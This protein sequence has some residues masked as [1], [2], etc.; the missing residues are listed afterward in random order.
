MLMQG[1][2]LLQGGRMKEQTT[3]VSTGISCFNNIFPCTET[4][5]YIKLL[6]LNSALLTL[7]S[8][9][10]LARVASTIQVESSSHNTAVEYKQHNG[11]ETEE[12]K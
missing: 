3:K 11:P 6:N 2:I 8:Y 10:Q 1:G 5:L 7:A 9:Y 12:E 4:E